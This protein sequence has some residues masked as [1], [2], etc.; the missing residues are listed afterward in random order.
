M[1]V[2][3]G[4]QVVIYLVVEFAF[5]Y[6]PAESWIAPLAHDWLRM[7]QVCSP[8]RNEMGQ[9]H[10]SDMKRMSQVYL[11]DMKR[12]SKVHLSDMNRMSQV[13]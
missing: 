10:L 2:E 7:G 8:S 1:K 6:S 5:P 13:H 4:Q 12:M 9:V 3:R 11:T